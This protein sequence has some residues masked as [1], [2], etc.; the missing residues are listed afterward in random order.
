MIPNNIKS[1]YVGNQQVSRIYL[2]NNLIFPVLSGFWEFT[3]INSTITGFSV[4]TVPTGTI[5]INW[6]DGTENIVNSSGTINKIYTV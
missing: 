5:T 4:T 2:G 3:E 1:G 6:G